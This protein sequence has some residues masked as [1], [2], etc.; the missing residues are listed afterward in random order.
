M[1]KIQICTALD[2]PEEGMTAPLFALDNEAGSAE[3][4][5]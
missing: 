3:C 4:T 5:S 1:T 2:V